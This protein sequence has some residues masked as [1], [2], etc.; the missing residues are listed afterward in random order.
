LAIVYAVMFLIIGSL[1]YIPFLNDAAGYTLG[2]F[3][4]EWHDD[5]LHYLSGLWAAAAAWISL[6]TGSRA[7]TWYFRL[8]GILYGLD[9]VMG[10]LLGQ[11]YLDGGIFLYGPTDLDWGFKFF[12]NLPH[13]LIGGLAVFIGFILSRK[14]PENEPS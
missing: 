7:A 8:F 4:L 14:F 5:T 12:A 1:S 9:G 11:G 10:L 13:I 2:I 3:R 6:R